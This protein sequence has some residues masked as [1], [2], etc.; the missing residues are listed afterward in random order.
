MS[1]DYG[2]SLAQWAATYGTLI[3]FCL[4][5]LATA[6]TLYRLWRLLPA[7]WSITWIAIVAIGIWTA[8]GDPVQTATNWLSLGTLTQERRADAILSREGTPVIA[9]DKPD[10]GNTCEKSANQRGASDC[11]TGNACLQR[12]NFYCLILR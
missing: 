3:I 4:I 1:R 7:R 10:V 6:F 8:V 11:E 9:A 12:H 5:C 2:A